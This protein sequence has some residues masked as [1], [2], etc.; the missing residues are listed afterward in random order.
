MDKEAKGHCP[1]LESPFAGCY[2]LRSE[3]IW[4]E[5]VLAL[6]AGRFELCEYFRMHCTEGKEV[7]EPGGVK[8]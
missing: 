5:R 2:C 3:S 6:C 8:E 1:Y 4:A 7:E